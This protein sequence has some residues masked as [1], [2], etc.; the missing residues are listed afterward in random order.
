MKKSSI[1]AN[2]YSQVA[3]IRHT[4]QVEEGQK[5]LRKN[6]GTPFK[7]TQKFHNIGLLLILTG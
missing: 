4:Y 6:K 5:S 7:E 3:K 2:F 1:E